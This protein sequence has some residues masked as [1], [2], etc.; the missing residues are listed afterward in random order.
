GLAAEGLEELELLRPQAHGPTLDAD[1]VARGIE[2][3][4][5]DLEGP[6][7][8]AAAGSSHD[9]VHARDELARVEWLGEVI[10]ETRVEAGDLLEVIRA[11]G[12]REDGSVVR[13]A[14][15]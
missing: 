12:E 10:V 1:F 9:R 8:G 13:P 15:L 6:R 11:R 4:V 3:E 14:E 7:A 2:D 5:A